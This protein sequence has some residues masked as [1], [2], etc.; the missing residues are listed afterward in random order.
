MRK[1]HQNVPAGK[2]VARTGGYVY[3]WIAKLQKNYSSLEEFVGICDIYN[4]HLKLGYSTPELAWEYNP[5]IQGGTNPADFCKIDSSG[6]R[7]WT[8]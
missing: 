4:L 6:R 3:G 2:I 1:Y 5:T 8:S 7:R